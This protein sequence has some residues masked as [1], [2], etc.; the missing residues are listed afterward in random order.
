MSATGRHGYTSAQMDAISEDRAPAMASHTAH[1]AVKTNRES[2]SVRGY[3][4]DAQNGWSW[5]GDPLGVIFLC[6]TLTLIVRGMWLSE[7]RARYRE[8][9]PNSGWK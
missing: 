5:E 6:S 3:G 1:I 9:A 7:A 2:A 8:S 4:N